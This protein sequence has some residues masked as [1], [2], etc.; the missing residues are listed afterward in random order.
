RQAWVDAK[1]RAAKARDTA[2]R[3]TKPD[4]SRVQVSGAERVKYLEKVYDDTDIKDKPRNF[5]GMAKSVP[6]EQMEEM[7]RGRRPV[8]ATGRRRPGRRRA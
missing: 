8:G 5:I 7:L 2:P 3:G 4:P 1:I 6:P